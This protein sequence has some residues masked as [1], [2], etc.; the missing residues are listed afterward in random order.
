[1]FQHKKNH[2]LTV[3]LFAAIITGKAQDTSSADATLSA[4]TVFFGNGAEL[5]HNA[6]VMVN[7]GTKQI[8]IS[9]LSTA[10]D[11]NSLQINV[12]ENVALLS[13][14]FALFT[15]N[16]TVVISPLIKKMQDSI[17]LIQKARSRINNLVEIEQATLDKTN[18]LIELAMK[19]ISNKTIAS[20]EAIKLINANT[21]KI[22]K[23]KTNLFNLREVFITTAVTYYLK[24][25]FKKVNTLKFNGINDDMIAD[26][27]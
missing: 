6:K 21:N 1:M 2:L 12:P 15:P 24:N 18:I 10:I 17:K 20:E 13:Q 25:G 3:I 9:Q 22:E 14:R 16:M 26:I 8:I 11:I 4:A 19:E 5:T 7:A 23:A 27:S